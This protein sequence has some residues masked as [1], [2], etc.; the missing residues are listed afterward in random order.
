[1]DDKLLEKK[2][3]NDMEHIYLTAKK[4]EI[5]P[6]K[7]DELVFALYGLNEDD[8]AIIKQTSGS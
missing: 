5:H 2:F 6:N 4:T 8:V 3:H 7:L 1:M